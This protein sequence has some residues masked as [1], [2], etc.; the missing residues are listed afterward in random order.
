MV[1]PLELPPIVRKDGNRRVIAWISDL[2]TLCNYGLAPRNFVGIEGNPLNLNPPQEELVGYFDQFVEACDRLE[3]DTLCLVGD[4]IH[5]GNVIDRGV[6][7]MSAN[8][9]DQENAGV[10][11]LL[12]PAKGRRLFFWSGS[13]YHIST[14]AHNTER[15]ICMNKRLAEVAESTH[16]MG[17]V[18]IMSFPPSEKKFLV[19]HGQSAAYIYR[20]MLMSRE[21]LYVRE[22]MAMGKVPPIDVIVKGHWHQFLH[23]HENQMHSIQ[24]PCWCMF[25]PWKG[26]LLSYGKHQPD[27]GGVITI[28]DEEDRLRVW[29]YLYPL[30]HL[31][32][33]PR[34]G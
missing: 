12:K 4:I 27:I 7:L 22:A 1:E 18:S 23:V 6:Q 16:W 14:K 25:I 34:K 31:I 29:H 3:T 13:G 11:L 9:D 5:G 19:H 20:T 33:V 26:S 28:L 17:P 10:D 8:L 2:H 32:D 30:P 15:D 21:A 24:L